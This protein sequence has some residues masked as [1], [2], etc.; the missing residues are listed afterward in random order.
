MVREAAALVNTSDSL[1]AAKALTFIAAAVRRD[2]ATYAKTA[3]ELALP[4]AIEMLKSRQVG[5]MVAE[6]KATSAGCSLPPSPL[7]SAL[8]ALFSALAS[9]PEKDGDRIEGTK[10]IAEL[11]DVAAAAAMDHCVDFCR[12]SGAGSSGSSSGSARGAHG[13]G[14]GGSGGGG[15]DGSLAG[16][17]VAARCVAAVAAAAVEERSRADAVT[18]FTE[19]L[20]RPDGGDWAA[21]L[22]QVLCVGELGRADC[23][24]VCSAYA[25][26]AASDLL[27]CAS[28]SGGEFDGLRA[29]AASSLGS[30]VSGSFEKLSPALLEATKAAELAAFAADSA[31]DGNAS[32]AA[33]ADAAASSDGDEGKTG[34]EESAGKTA[35]SAARRHRHLLYSAWETCA[36]E[37]STLRF[38]LQDMALA[39]ASAAPV[40]QVEVSIDWNVWSRPTRIN[41]GCGDLDDDG[42]AKRFVC[43][44]IN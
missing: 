12:R 27:S 22:L 4:R 7:L 18:R 34:G 17:T 32:A 3:T 36:G 41:C 38:A 24:D 42:R 20:K 16:A 19:A 23:L 8:C 14:G 44:T 28:G 37:L 39:P 2:A 1:L 15:G 21:R 13:G 29:A 35:G 6:G 10:S 26:S 11:V 33:A 40:K 31:A 9:L 43:T 25:P 30:L 5:L